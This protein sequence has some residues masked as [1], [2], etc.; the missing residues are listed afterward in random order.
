MSEPGTLPTVLAVAV[1]MQPQ[2]EPQDF[3]RPSS[4]VRRW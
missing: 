3:G 1:Q 2:P 4:P